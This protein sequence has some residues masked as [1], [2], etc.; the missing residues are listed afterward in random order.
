MRR[1]AAA[2][3]A[4]SDENRRTVLAADSDR[5]LVPVAPL[6][7]NAVPEA[8]EEPPGDLVE[9]CARA[10]G[11][12]R[13]APLLE[14]VLGEVL[15]QKC[16][17]SGLWWQERMLV[18]TNRR[19]PA[20]FAASPRLRLPTV[21]I[22]SVSP[23]LCRVQPAAEVTTASAPSMARSGEGGS[24]MSPPRDLHPGLLQAARV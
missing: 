5:A 7:G 1:M 13:D 23:L 3:H 24:I 19:T 6:A 20:W 21:S 11:N 18:S 17:T 2:L 8:A 10:Q 12:E 16:G 4:L 15:C 9:E 22:T 14:T